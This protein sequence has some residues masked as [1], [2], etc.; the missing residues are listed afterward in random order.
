MVDVGRRGG[1]KVQFAVRRSRDDKSST[2]ISLSVPGSLLA[3]VQF[4][5]HAFVAFRIPIS[6]MSRLL[7]IGDIHG[8][9]T[10]LETLARF[11]PLADDDL[12]V[13]LG[14]YV[15]RGPETREVL[16]WLIARHTKGRLIPLYGNHEIVML[17]A[18][19]DEAAMPDWIKMGGVAVLS[20]YGRGQPAELSDVPETHWHFLEHETRR[21]YETDTHFFVHASARADL[22]LAEQPDNVLFW[23]RFENSLPH[24]S[25]KIM[26]CGHSAQRSGLP[27]NLGHAIGID[28]WVYGDGWLTCLEPKTGEFWQAN[29]RGETRRKCL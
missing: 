27:L 24:Q 8:C 21:F 15:D 5:T 11:I 18:R 9:Y 12:L 7:A 25:N 14:D 4:R 22:P 17:H 3:M 16:E 19:D 6:T 28:T 10:A 23:E 20:S 2:E 13:T 1:A 26:I 29:S